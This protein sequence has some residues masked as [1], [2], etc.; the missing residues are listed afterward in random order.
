MSLFIYMQ[1]KLH[2]DRTLNG[3]V[4]LQLHPL[5]DDLPGH[6]HRFKV[7]LHPKRKL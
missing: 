4:Q 3:C 7:A 5:E 1:L 6:D 2:A